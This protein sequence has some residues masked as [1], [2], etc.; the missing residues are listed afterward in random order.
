[1]VLDWL[2]ELAKNGTVPTQAPGTTVSTE[3]CVD[4]PTTQAT[5]PAPTD[6]P[7]SPPITDDN[8]ITV[9]GTLP[10]DATTPISPSNDTETG[11]N[12][13]GEIAGDPHVLVGKLGGTKICFNFVGD[14]HRFVDLISDAVTGFEVNAEIKTLRD[15]SRLIQIGIKY[16]FENQEYRFMM[17]D[18]GI[19]IWKNLVIEETISYGTTTR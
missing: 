15:T 1:M 4:C 2:L 19:S 9:I 3:P 8:G 14:D 17:D 13:D 6:A 11:D 10:P 5:T 18:T 16:A 7:T 12:G